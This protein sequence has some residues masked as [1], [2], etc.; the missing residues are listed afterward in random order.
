MGCGPSQI[1]DTPEDLGY[2]SV[3]FHWVDVLRMVHCDR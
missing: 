3:T 2:A 1:P